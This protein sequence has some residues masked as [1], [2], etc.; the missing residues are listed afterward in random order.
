MW[1][2]KRHLSSQG[3]CSPFNNVEFLL[4]RGC[5][6]CHTHSGTTYPFPPLHPDG[7]KYLVLTYSMNR[8]DAG[9]FWAKEVKKQTPPHPFFLLLPMEIEISSS[10]CKGLGPQISKLRNAAFLLET[11]T[12]N[13][14]VKEKLSLCR[15]TEIWE[16]NCYS[17]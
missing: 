13:F 2:A 6:L 4:E 14:W 16:F 11:S 12:L 8:S 5:P 15:V 10:R 17:T 7:V 9:R 1:L 3:S